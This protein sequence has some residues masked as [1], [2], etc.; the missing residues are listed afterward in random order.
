MK[1]VH[2]KKSGEKMDWLQRFFTSFGHDLWE[3]LKIGGRDISEAILELL[4]Y[5]A[6]TYLT[7]GN[8]SIPVT[9]AIVNIVLTVAIVFGLAFLMR[10]LVLKPGSKA[11]VLS[12]KLFETICGFSQSTGLSKAQAREFAPFVASLFFYIFISNMLPVFSIE[13]AAVNPAFPIAL[14]FFTM[15]CIVVWGI[16]FVGLKG[17]LR[18]LTAPMKLLLPFNLL[19]Y[20]IKPISLAF[21]LFGN[22]FGASIL[23]TF[24]HSIMPLFLPQILGLWF[25]IGDGIVQALVFAYLSMTYIG[26][27]VEKA[28]IHDIEEAAAET[29]DKAIA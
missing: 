20:V 19:D 23:I 27:I 17:F 25:D 12:E 28:E 1:P 24:L 22:I 9:K 6:I 16:Y 26:E 7:I 13:A 3:H 2:P 4:D 21:R 29:N 8:F 10:K 18:S 11:Q 14:A 5:S 15:A